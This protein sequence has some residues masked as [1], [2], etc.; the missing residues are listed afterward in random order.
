MHK[1]VNA[2]RARPCFM[3]WGKPVT[4]SR[5]EHLPARDPR[6]MD[7]KNAQDRRQRGVRTD[8][9]DKIHPGEREERPVSSYTDFTRGGG[10][11]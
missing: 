1:G 7:E 8:D 3:K 9:Y 10:S 5:I 11:Y 2:D 4:T 6:R